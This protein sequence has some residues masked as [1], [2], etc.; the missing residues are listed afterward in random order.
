M[1]SKFTVERAP[2]HADDLVALVEQELGEVGAVL[3]GDAGDERALG[4]GDRFYPA[5]AR[6]LPTGLARSGILSDES[7]W[8]LGAD[9]PGSRRADSLGRRIAALR[10]RAGLDP[11]GAGRPA[12]HLPRRRSPTSRP[13]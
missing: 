3:A 13:A 6:R 10:A 9:W 8:S 4:H 5:S 2:D 11:A 1:R 7:P 12:R